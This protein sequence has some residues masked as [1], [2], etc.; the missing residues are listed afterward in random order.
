MRLIMR[1]ISDNNSTIGF[2]MNSKHKD[3]N[4]IDIQTLLI[5]VNHRQNITYNNL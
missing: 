4:N 3:L 2:K 5:L 1:I